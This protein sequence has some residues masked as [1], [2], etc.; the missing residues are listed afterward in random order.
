MTLPSNGETN[1]L[2]LSSMPRL[3]CTYSRRVAG[4]TGRQSP[5]SAS[6]AAGLHARRH[7][8]W[9]CHERCVVPSDA[10]DLDRPRGDSN[11]GVENTVK[12]NLD[13][14]NSGSTI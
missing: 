7:K 1:I 6:L 2:Y 3:V 8:G 10:S 11:L 12:L 13:V 5:P 9:S 4:P 14:F